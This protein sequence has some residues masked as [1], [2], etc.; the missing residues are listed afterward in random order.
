MSTTADR[1]RECRT[2]AGLSQSELSDR[3]SVS[4]Q[5]VSKWESGAGLP[6]VMNLKAMARLF[7]VSVDFLIAEDSAAGTGE[8]T[9]RQSIDLAGFEPHRQ[10]GKPMGS[11]HHAAVLA[12]YPSARVWEVAR[13]HRTTGWRHAMEWFLAFFTDG[14]GFGLF[15]TV[16]GLQNH[17]AYYLVETTHKQ[18]LVRVGAHEMTSRE[19]NEHVTANRFVI[20]DDSFR[21]L[22][23]L[24]RA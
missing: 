15:G 2:A 18:L 14:P 1:I 16:D 10:P 13:L 19:L 5:A 24:Q 9:M 12:A 22:P 3:L 17:D 20:G 7:D 6:D 11:R 4:R 23:E 8:V 21:R